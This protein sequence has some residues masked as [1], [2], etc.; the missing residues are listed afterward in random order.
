MSLP[1]FIA[2]V[3]LWLP[4]CF[5]VWYLGTPL[6]VWPTALLAQAVL[7]AGFGDFI[8]GLEVTHGTFVALT[9]LRPENA[10][11]GS[12]VVLVPEVNALVYS[13]GMPLFAALILAV[14]EP[15]WARKLLIGLGV[16]LPL[17]VVGV[18]ADVLR[19]IAIIAGP[20]V[21]LQAGF[22]PW[23]REAV[24]FVFQ[25]SSLIVPAVAPA[26]LWVIL[27]RRFLERWRQSAASAAGGSA[28]K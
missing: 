13:F 15:G 14:R 23:Q 22:T 12:S 11:L 21:A 18:V 10:P 16:L 19:Q 2:K 5:A 24:V 3:F 1:R 27:E 25:F 28:A 8:R 9:S 6:L 20:G 7:Q 26:I 4:L 17:Q